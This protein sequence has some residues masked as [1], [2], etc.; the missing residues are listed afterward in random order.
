MC[1]GNSPEKEFLES[2]MRQ[3]C[4]RSTVKRRQT[5]IEEMVQKFDELVAPYGFPWKLRD[6][7]PKALV[8]GQD[9]GVLTEEGAKAS[10][11]NVAKLKAGIPMCPPEGDAGTGMVATNSVRRAYR[12]CFRRN[13]CI[14][15]DRLWRRHFPNRIKKSIWLPLRQDIW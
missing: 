12:K 14:C 3:V 4:S 5:I 2:V 7:M 1:T 10:G 8:A 9:A 11:C 6:I 15:H 13:F